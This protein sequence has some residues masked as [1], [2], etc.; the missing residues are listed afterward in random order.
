MECG[1][2]LPLRHC[3]ANSLSFALFFSITYGKFMK[4]FI[5]GKFH[6]ERGRESIR[7][8]L[9]HAFERGLILHRQKLEFVV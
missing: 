1:I 4:I 8:F 5:D 2:E 9:G 7:R 3:H 6:G